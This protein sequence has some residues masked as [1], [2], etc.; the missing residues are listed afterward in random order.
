MK[1]KHHCFLQKYLKDCM[2][3]PLQIW[4]EKKQHTLKMQIP[5]APFPTWTQA[6]TPK[7]GGRKFLKA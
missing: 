4:Q 3:K 6:Y 7:F 5:N 2:T 1:N